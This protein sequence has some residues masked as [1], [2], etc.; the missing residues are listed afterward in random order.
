VDGYHILGENSGHNE[1]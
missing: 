1:G